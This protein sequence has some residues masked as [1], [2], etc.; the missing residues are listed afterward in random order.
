MSWNKNADLGSVY[1]TW[2]CILE[3]SQ[4]RSA[5][6]RSVSV[7]NVIERKLILKQHSYCEELH[8]YGL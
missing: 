4:G 1:E 3:A 8:D 5:D 6:L 7:S 2:A